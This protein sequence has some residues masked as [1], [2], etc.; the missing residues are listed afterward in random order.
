MGALFKLHI[1]GLNNKTYGKNIT[2][3]FEC[4]LC[5]EIESCNTQ[6]VCDPCDN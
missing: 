5:K 4:E 3:I 6:Y 1:M 2:T